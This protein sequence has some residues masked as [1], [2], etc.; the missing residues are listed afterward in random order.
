ML[1]YGGIEGG[2][3]VTGR[4]NSLVHVVDK[5]KITV[6]DVYVGF[7]GSKKRGGTKARV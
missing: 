4:F 1:R 6:F 2:R 7:H 3:R 5:I